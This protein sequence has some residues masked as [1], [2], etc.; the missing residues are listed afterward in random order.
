MKW[1]WRIKSNL[2]NDKCVFNEQNIYIFK[3]ITVEQISPHGNNT[4][5]GILYICFLFYFEMSK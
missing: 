2:I 4:T 5:S 1:N 3:F